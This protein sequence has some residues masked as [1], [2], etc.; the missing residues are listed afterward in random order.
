MVGISSSPENS[1]A[2][3]SQQGRDSLLVETVLD[4]RGK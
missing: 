1:Q 2:L 4:E 3:Q